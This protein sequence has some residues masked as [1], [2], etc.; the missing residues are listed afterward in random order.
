MDKKQTTRGNARP[1]G[2]QRS[3]QGQA[4][5]TASGQSQRSA[6][7]QA[8][9]NPYYSRRR[10][11][12]PVLV[13]LI[14]ALV[15]VIAVFAGLGIYV[16]RYNNYDKI[17]PNVYLAGINVGGMTREEARQAVSENITETTQQSIN[18]NLPDQTLTFTPKQDTVLLNV[19]QAVEEAYAYGRTNT[20]AFTLARAIQAAERR[21]NDI[22]IQSA[23]NVDYDYIRR[24]IDDTAAEV[25]TPLVETQMDTDTEAR[26]IT[27]TIGSPS[28]S[29][30]ADR[31]YELVSTAF[32]TA[33]Y[34]DIDFDYDVTY[35][36]PVYLDDAYNYLT[37]EGSDAKYDPGTGNISTETVGYEP[38]VSLEQANEQ[39]AMASP[40]D[41]LTFTFVETLPE[42]TAEELESLLF[43][44]V[45]ASK[46]TYYAANANRTRNL[47]L[48]C[49]AIDGTVL[50]PGEVFSFKTTD[51][52]GN[53]VDSAELFSKAKVTVVNCWGTWC[54]P[55][56]AELPELGVMAK[57][58]EEQGCQLVGLCTDA[59]DDEV[60]A[61]AKALL[62]DAGA[63]YLNLRCTEEIEEDISLT[64]YP[65]TY[66]VDSEG[67]L[68]I[69]P[70]EGAS[71][72]NYRAL[73]ADCLAQLG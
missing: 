56:K 61:A 4:A 14:V 48:A 24:L 10:R 72:E 23:V 70:F 57:E 3:T 32:S 5:R 40:G 12:S 68:L 25:E 2:T 19:D 55:C 43:R 71:P 42:V 54:N 64:A 13:V 37:T 65:T 67:R 51:L 38:A 27:V 60:A 17:L 63:A 8:R 26:I 15:L 53:A 35:P 41:V 73:L 46:G 50:Q 39:L 44:D 6:S 30:D 16:M 20:N 31:L 52:D 11:V 47:E 18:V 59:F 1:A 49:D 58:L 22:D 62:N 28:R 29:I 33:N 21:R 36:A 66:F 45:L 9:P 69:A 34:S 7:A